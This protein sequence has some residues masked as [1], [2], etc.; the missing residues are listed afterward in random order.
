[1]P[2]VSESAPSSI[3][4]A[5]ATPAVG[6]APTLTDRFA[7]LAWGALGALPLLTAGVLL[8]PSTQGMG[9]HQQLG[10]PPCTFLY[11]TDFPC[12]FC[13]MTTSWTHAAHGQVFESIRT[14]PMGFAFFA[15]DFGLVVWILGLALLGRAQ[16]RPERFLSAIPLPL[17]WSGLSLTIVAWIYK[18]ATVRGWL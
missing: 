10:L 16:F 14:Q 9:T 12:P 18:I 11:L 8:T 3:E 6:A 7:N 15:I 2:G 1:M 13:G 17:W 4:S 5:S